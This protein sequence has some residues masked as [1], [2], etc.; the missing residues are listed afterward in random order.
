MIRELSWRRVMQKFDFDE[1]QHLAETDPEVFELRRQQAIEAVIVAAPRNRQH[2]LRGLQWRVDMERRK[3]K[4]SL[5]S[6]QKVFGMMWKSVY[7]DQGLMQ[8]LQTFPERQTETASS[9]RSGAK[10]LAFEAS[11][12]GD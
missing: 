12:S 8:A 5:R 2:R 11:S 10:V 3:H 4:E 9:R 1:W 7:G 6:C